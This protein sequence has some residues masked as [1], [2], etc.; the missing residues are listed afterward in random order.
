MALDAYGAD[1]GV[2]IGVRPSVTSVTYYSDILATNP[3]PEGVTGS[4][5]Y[6]RI[7]FSE[8]VQNINGL[9][10]RQPTI[11]LATPDVFIPGREGRARY[12]I[13]AHDAELNDT[14]CRATSDTATNEYLCQIDTAFVRDYIRVEVGRDTHDL[15]GYTLE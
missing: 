3:I 11:T 8:N 4:V 10:G 14:H 12:A 13:V 15:V 2:M 5:I 7:L 6:A 9:N 1:T